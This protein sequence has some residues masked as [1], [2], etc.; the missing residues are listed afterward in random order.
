MAIDK[1]SLVFRRVLMISLVSLMPLVPQCRWSHWLVFSLWCFAGV[2]RKPPQKS[3]YQLS[4][5]STSIYPSL[6]SVWRKQASGQDQRFGIRS[7]YCGSLSRRHQSNFLKA[8]FRAPS[9]EELFIGHLL[10]NLEK[11]FFWSGGS[12]ASKTIH[13]SINSRRSVHI[14][15]SISLRI[16]SGSR[17]LQCL[18]YV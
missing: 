3:P 7:S 2:L 1:L 13:C 18:P 4:G 14:F 11:S 8:K 9:P 6:G 15:L 12:G 17:L 5:W 10:G 16:H